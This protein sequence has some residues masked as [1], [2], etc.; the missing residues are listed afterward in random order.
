M[1]VKEPLP[2]DHP[3]WAMGNVILSPHIGAFNADYV[4]QVLPFV[5]ENLAHY[6]AG[7]F[8]RMINVVRKGSGHG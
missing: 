8:E 6:L 4:S 7:R 1:F 2:A 3:F 5:E